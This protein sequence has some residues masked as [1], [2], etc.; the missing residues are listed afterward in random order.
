M[1]NRFA[2]GDVFEVRLDTLVVGFFQYVAR[3]SSQ[4]NSHVVRAF[5]RQYKETDVPSVSQIVREKVDFYAHVFLSV[6]VKQKIWR[7]VASGN[8]IGEVDVLFRDSNDYGKS[9]RKTS[10]DWYVWRIDGPY[11]QIGALRDDCRNA[12]I[13]V[14]V[15]PDSLVYRMRNGSYDFFYP[16]PES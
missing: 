4:L 16:D 8:I 2:I 1:S 10:N 6:G 15:P 9:K 13:G 14:V 3:D 12:E 7:K 5:E 11:Q